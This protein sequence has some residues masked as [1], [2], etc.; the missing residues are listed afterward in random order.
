MPHYVDQ[1]LGVATMLYEN[2]RA[3]RPSPVITLSAWVANKV[4]M[5]FNDHPFKDVSSLSRSQY[6]TN[7]Q[8]SKRVSVT[9]KQG[10]VWGQKNVIYPVQEGRQKEVSNKRMAD[11]ARAA[12]LPV[13]GIPSE[14]PAWNFHHLWQS[15]T[16]LTSDSIDCCS[17]T[18]AKTDHIRPSIMPLT[19][20]CSNSLQKL[21]GK[22]LTPANLASRSW[23][24]FPHH[25]PRIFS[26]SVAKSRRNSVGGWW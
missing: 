23:K 21:L 6:S 10:T 25:K 14:L 4:A 1:V 24:R 12:M 5:P 26:T 2:R 11:V 3:T 17:N 7:P 22:S 18:K 16:R 20:C 9:L 8:I 19:K 13:L 15:I